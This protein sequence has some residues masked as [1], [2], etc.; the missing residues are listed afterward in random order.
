MILGHC[1]KQCEVI[2]QIPIS[3]QEEVTGARF[4]GLPHLE[5][6]FRY[7]PQHTFIAWVPLYGVFIPKWNLTVPAVI[8]ERIPY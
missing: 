1:P 5:H 4:Q 3:V 6:K 7:S 8:L 2:W